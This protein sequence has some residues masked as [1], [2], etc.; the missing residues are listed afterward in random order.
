MRFDPT[1]IT[2]ISAAGIALATSVITAYYTY[3]SRSRELDIELV[4]LG[5]SVLQAAPKATEKDGKAED[6]GLRGW[7][8]D[9]VETYSGKRLSPLAREQLQ[10]LGDLRFGTPGRV[11]VHIVKSALAYVGSYNGPI[12]D[13]E[14]EPFRKA[15]SDFQKTRNIQPDGILSLSTLEALRRAAPSYFTIDPLS[16]LERLRF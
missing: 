5:L 13:K 15:I 7:A 12:D 6:E 14:D 2:T 3:T 16:D 11:P 9:V 8:V 4:K 1:Q 10:Q